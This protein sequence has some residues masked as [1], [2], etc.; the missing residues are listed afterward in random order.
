[1][2]QNF[3]PKPL[4]AEELNQTKNGV[5]KTDYRL[6]VPPV[7]NHSILTKENSYDEHNNSLL[8]NTAYSHLQGQ[9]NFV[10][11]GYSLEPQVY[12]QNQQEQLYYNNQQQYYPELTDNNYQL[13][14]ALYNMEDPQYNYENYHQPNNEN[15]QYDYDTYQ[16]LQF[17]N[18]N[19]TY[20][21][22]TSNY[23]PYPAQSSLARS[24][25]RATIKNNKNDA[26][27]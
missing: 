8:Q 22:N 4:T 20:H 6:G 12:P 21:F 10:A 23:Q 25:V 7:V 19:E 26:D 3:Q 14:P 5:N 16:N 24:P 27:L 13:D 9:K 2:Y 15:F 17:N 11:N 18:N 1:Q